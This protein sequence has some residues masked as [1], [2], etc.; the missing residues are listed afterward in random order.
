VDNRLPAPV[1]IGRAK[2]LIAERSQT[3]SDYSE[4]EQRFLQRVGKPR[5]FRN[6]ALLVGSPAGS[7]YCAHPSYQA[8][9][10]QFFLCVLVDLQP[11]YRDGGMEAAHWVDEGERVTNECLIFIHWAKH[12]RPDEAWQCH[13]SWDFSLILPDLK[14]EFWNCGSPTLRNRRWQRSLLVFCPSQPC[15][16]RVPRGG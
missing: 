1:S 3:G 4:A 6:F 2:W 14:S 11:A 13:A 16:K 7:I 8:S 5:H 15:A 12:F 9:D 10:R